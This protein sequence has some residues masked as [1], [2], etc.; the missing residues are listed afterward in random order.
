MKKGY[1]F[2]GRSQNMLELMATFELEALSVLSFRY[3]Y[4]LTPTLESKDYGDNQELTNSI[5]FISSNP[6]VCLSSTVARI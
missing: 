4:I 2:Q 6:A 1:S 5:S 3:G